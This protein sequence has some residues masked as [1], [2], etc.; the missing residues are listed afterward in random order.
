MQLCRSAL[1]RTKESYIYVCVSVCMCI[2][3][4]CSHAS[5]NPWP[6]LYLNK[7]KETEGWCLTQ[8][9][10]HQAQNPENSH[11]PPLQTLLCSV[12]CPMELFRSALY[13]T[14]YIFVL[15]FTCKFE[16]MTLALFDQVQRDLRVV[17]EGPVWD[18]TLTPAK[19]V[20]NLK[21]RA[22]GHSKWKSRRSTW[23]QGAYCESNFQRSCNRI[24]GANFA[25]LQNEENFGTLRWSMSCF[26]V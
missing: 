16:P 22:S 21:W 8:Q 9:M 23:L 26:N 2:L 18:A 25:F 24:V 5:L 12:R 10:I 20:G 1:Y 7:S 15:L 13:R 4:C 6:V 19:F 17:L 14:L 3:S 11:R